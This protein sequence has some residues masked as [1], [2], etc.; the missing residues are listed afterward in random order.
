MALA[1]LLTDFGTR[2]AYVSIMKGVMLK[3][4]PD[5]SLV[6]LGHEVAPQ[7]VREGAYLLF[8]AYRYFPAGTVFCCVVDP[9]AGSGRRAIAVQIQVSEAASYTFVCPDNGLLTPVLQQHAVQAAVMLDNPRYHLPVVSATFHG[10]DIFAP[11]AAHLASG[12]PLEALGSRLEPT[13]LAQLDWPQPV[14]D[15]QGWR[16]S[17][18][19]ADRFG[20]LITN[21]PGEALE[22][23]L[24]SWNVHLEALTI[25]GIKPT[26]AAVRL[27]A[28]VAYVGDSG[29][30]EL[31][32][33]QGNAQRTWQVEVGDIVKLTPTSG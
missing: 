23:P 13:S 22:P 14:R 10:R 24:K 21:L 20:N 6:D 1:T 31:A 11:A 2:D 17:I 3:V 15:G 9:G 16:A 4:A 30:V 29:F 32:V 7:D 25:R 12:V 28:P 8:T 33:R 19:H 5:L 27:G 18:L 26:F